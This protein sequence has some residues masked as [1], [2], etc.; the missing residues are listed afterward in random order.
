MIISPFRLKFIP[1]V[2]KFFREGAC[3]GNDLFCVLFERR[4]GR[5]LQGGGNTCNSLAKNVTL[6]FHREKWSDPTLL[7]G[8]PWHAGNTASFTRF[9]RSFAFSQSFRKKIKPARGPRRV[10][11]LRGPT[12]LRSRLGKIK[13][14]IRGRGHH[15]TIIKRI[16]KFPCGY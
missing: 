9:S 16:L 12:L 2:D 1:I 3:I 10:L 4:I 5:L 7:W 15:V 11:W 13:D 6:I 14:H 8:P